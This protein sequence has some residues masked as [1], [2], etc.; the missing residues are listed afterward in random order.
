MRTGWVLAAAVAASSV[1][2]AE[3]PEQRILALVNHYRQVAGVGPVRLDAKLSKGCMEHAEYMKLNRGTPA[4]EGL[5][6]HNQ[7]PSRP[8]ATLAGAACGKAAD[9]FPGVSDLGAA[10]DGWMAGLYH[11]RPILAPTLETIGFGY[12]KLPDGTFMAAL[13]FVDGNGTSGWPV[14]YP[15]KD[16]TGIPLE[17]AHEIPNP[18]PGGGAGGY[19]ITLQFPPFDAVTG[20]TATLVDATGAAVPFHLSTP[21]RPATSFGQ[22]GVIC[23]IPKQRLRAETQYTATIKATWNKQART[24]TSRFTTIGLRRLDAADQDALLAAL[25]V[26]SLVHGTVG[27]G[28]MMNTETVFLQLGKSDGARMVSII[29]PVRLWK[30][31]AHGADPKA[32]AGKSVEVE[33]SPQLVHDRYLNLTITE[34]TQ[35]RIR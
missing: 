28:G 29:I 26:P 9:L 15:A 27:Y 12:A 6:A 20:V 1:A 8:G 32:F 13:M 22:Y 5:A 17:F 23:L 16:Q 34:A 2:R 21:E 31:I 10:V 11:R 3:P 35:L 7:D 25:G 18:I 33:A 14:A 19:P 24:Y 30:A 4:M